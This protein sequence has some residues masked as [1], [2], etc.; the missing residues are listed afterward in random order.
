MSLIQGAMALGGAVANSLDIGGNRRR[1]KQVEQQKK[2]T[3][4]QIGA[5]KELADY[6]MGISKEMFE[7][8]GYG[9][10]RKQMEDAGL[11]PALMYGHAGAG[12]S[13][14]SASAGSASGGQAS[15]EA[16]QKMANAQSQGMAL[17]LAKLGSE[18][19]INK[20]QAKKLD[21]EADKTVGVDTDLAKANIENI[22]ED[23]NNKMVQREGM[24]LQ[25]NYDEMRNA[26]QSGSFNDNLRLLE[27][28]AK[29]AEANVKKLLE[30][31]HGMDI[32]NRLKLQNFEELSERIRL[33][34]E[35]LLAD[36]LVK[37]SQERLNDT[38]ANALVKELGMK[39]QQLGIN[40]DKISNEK[41]YN[42]LFKYAA[43]LG[44][45]TQRDNNLNSNITMITSTLLGIIG[46]TA[47]NKGKARPVKGFGK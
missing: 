25:N 43:E 22:T 37:G 44:S 40:M 38:T 31:V 28:Q 11:N 41:E 45:E 16:S 24:L 20:A 19:A 33:E 9:A 7:H 10:Q 15:D 4:I 47:G 36:I 35:Q 2:L 14:A 12:G 32:D 3:D 42:K 13:T 46:L 6:G 21:A 27:Y 5:N 1:E 29:Q 30:E 34:N 8:T 18:I 17:Q 39:M 23:I 26:L